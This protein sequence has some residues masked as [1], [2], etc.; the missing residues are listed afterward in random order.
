M[1]TALSVFIKPITSEFGWTRST[2]AGAGTVGTILGGLTALLVG[3]SI[4]RF[5]ARWVLLAAC[6]TTGVFFLL[7]GS[8][9]GLWQFYLLI[10]G[11]RLVLQ[12]LL[13]IANTVVVSKW[14]VAL[15]GRA[16]AIASLGP[17][18]GTG[19]L[20]FFAQMITSG[21]GW[22]MAAV[23]LGS[24]ILGVTLLP[25]LLWLRRRPEDMGLVPDGRPLGAPLRGAQRGVRTTPTP[26][27]ET[28]YSLRQVLRF[29]GFYIL[30]LGFI[31]SQF[32]STGIN[33]NLVPYLTD[34]GVSATQA[35]V[36]LSIWSLIG[37]PTTLL[38]GYLA[39]RVRPQLLLFGIFAGITAGSAILLFA[40]N[41]LLGI[42]FA[43]VHGSFFG[44]MLLF[45][46]LAFADYY[47]RGSLGTIRGFITPFLM[48]SNALGP[49]VAT[50]VFDT[51]GSYTRIFLVY[52]ALSAVAT[53]AMLFAAP[54]T[55]RASPGPG[56]PA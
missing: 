39:E 21:Y 15:R 24:V 12:G 38:A 22:R 2:F 56:V 37:I 18:L 30:L 3:P 46:T 27:V 32:V 26:A 49:L 5:G 52:V 43:V 29:R 40:D 45:Q 10:V 13:N 48:F 35:V 54:P 44:S 17:R 55:R 33:F 23:S 20:P 42:L 9:H 50:A 41:F 34:R 6:L 31:F 1:N 51:T 11:G 47:G 53:V 4:D 14:F 7:L 16:T 8:V 25:V 36:I 19:I 28:S